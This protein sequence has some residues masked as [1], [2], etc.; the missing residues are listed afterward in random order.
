MPILPESFEYTIF[1]TLTIILLCVKVILAVYLFIEILE[2]KRREGG[3]LKIDFVFSIFIFMV[4]LTISRLIYMIF[5]FHL[6]YF[7]PDT[8]FLPPNYI[9]W[10]IA[11]AISI[12][13]FAF[14][15]YIIDKKALHFKFK[16]IL[17]YFPIAIAIIICL[18]PI[19]TPSDFNFIS[20]LGIISIASGLLLI[21]LFI[22]IAITI[23]PL[24]KTSLIITFG[25]MVY[26]FGAV[27]I[28]EFVLEPSRAIFG[29]QIHILTYFIYLILKILGLVL[30]SYSIKKFI[31]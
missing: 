9:F 12:I 24:R 14:I 25:F 27:L 10:K 21:V 15:I 19:N 1:L 28:N 17:S 7:D 5:D 18:W 30:I 2:R 22:Y 13:G 3:K 6:T 8:Y 20:L 4:C 11:I 31:V 29:P 23:Q 26:A 16:G